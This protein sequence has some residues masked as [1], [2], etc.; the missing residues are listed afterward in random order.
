MY[1]YPF[2]Q[3]VPAT[4]P[5]SSVMEVL[6]EATV[7]AAPDQAQIVLGAVTEGP[8]LRT[9]QAENAAIITNVIQSLIS[10]PIPREKIQT[11]DYRIEVQYDYQDGKQ[12]FRGY[13][14]THLLKITTEK[15]S[16]TGMIVDTAVSQGANT[17]SSIRFTMANPGIYEN[18]ALT[19]A[20]RN[21]RQKAMA[22]AQAL[23]V[24]LS[25]VPSEVQELSRTAAPV[26]FKA[27]LF[28]ESASTPIQP[29][30]ITVYAAVRV[31]YPFG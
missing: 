21:A 30:E 15:V 6:G 28:A 1:R 9:V 29:G 8:V 5:K 16:Q 7:T 23:E 2:H 4:Q 31:R 13:K 3:G 22:L 10:I 11:E 18:Q 19:L 17:V 14:V 24:T 25:A 26:P 27:S 12:V 20:V